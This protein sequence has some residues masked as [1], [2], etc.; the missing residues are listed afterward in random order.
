MRTDFKVTAHALKWIAIITMMIDHFGAIILCSVIE[1]YVRPLKLEEAEELILASPRL[2]GLY[3]AYA[4]IRTI[5]RVSFPIFAYLLTEGFLHT[6][7]A[8]AYLRRL[9][10]F[11]FISEIPYN[12]AFGGNFFYPDGCNVFFTLAIGMIGMMLLKKTKENF[13]GS[14]LSFLFAITAFGAIAIPLFL[15]VSWMKS[16]I[17][18]L[19]EL[20]LVF[21][22]GI[23]MFAGFSVA[24][25][26]AFLLND[27]Q[28]NVITRTVF[29]MLPLCLFAEVIG[30]SYGATGVFVILLSY[31]LKEGKKMSPG[32]VFAIQA[33]VLSLSDM[34]EIFGLV[35][36]P[37]MDAYDGSQGRKGNRWFFYVFYPAH[38]FLFWMISFSIRLSVL[39]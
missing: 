10:L 31:A 17:L 30:S 33:A 19:D 6:K 34:T 35:L 12:L 11:A 2:S 15:K 23:G 7:D 39:F 4:L 26:L 27:D 22:S 3:S 25:F 5:G 28:R 16:L 20:T 24:V 29:I 37:V 38:L 18:Q 21:L 32:N 8:K 36:C 1:A 13:H 9:I 14:V